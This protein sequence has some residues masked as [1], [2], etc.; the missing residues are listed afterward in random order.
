MDRRK[1]IECIEKFLKYFNMLK[2]EFPLFGGYVNRLLTKV[3]LLVYLNKQSVNAISLL[4]SQPE[5]EL[6]IESMELPYKLRTNGNAN[7]LQQ[8]ISEIASR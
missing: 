7:W 6:N 3:C 1:R 5:C 4:C 2:F 8:Y